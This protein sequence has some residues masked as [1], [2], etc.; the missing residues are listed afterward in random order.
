MRRRE[1]DGTPEP[2]W[3]G[4]NNRGSGLHDAYRV[5]ENA[6]KELDAPG[7]WFCGKP[8]GKLYFC[9]PAEP[10]PPGPVPRRLSRTI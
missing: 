6:F 1:A 4:D 9:P 8:T 7:E 5:V 3:G 2:A 10:T